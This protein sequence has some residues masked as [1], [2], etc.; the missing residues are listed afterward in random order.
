MSACVSSAQLCVCGCVLTDQSYNWWENGVCV[1]LSVYVHRTLGFGF[2]EVSL[3]CNLKLLTNNYLSPT[4]ASVLRAVGKPRWFLW[5]L[6][7]NFGLYFRNS[8]HYQ[9]QVSY[10]ICINCW[11][12][13]ISLPTL[14]MTAVSN[15]FFSLLGLNRISLQQRQQTL[16]MHVSWKSAT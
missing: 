4:S 1:F 14:Q 7:G 11:L 13:T 6:L 8:V 2:C 5:F 9:P 12:K 16:H 3:S 10:Y 15:F